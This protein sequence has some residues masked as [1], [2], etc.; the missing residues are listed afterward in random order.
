M[1]IAAF[2]M[3]A[4]VNS[5]PGMNTAHL[6]GF[7]FTLIYLISAAI[8]FMPVLYLFQFSQK[9]NAGLQGEDEAVIT[10]GFRALKSHYRYMGIMMIVVMSLYALLIVFGVIGA[11]ITAAT[12]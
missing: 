5:V 9:M 4:I 6:P 10:E 3:G 7:V 11:I 2:A 8:Y 1:V 12:I